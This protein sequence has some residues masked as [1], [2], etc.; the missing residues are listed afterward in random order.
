MNIEFLAED[1]RPYT[2]SVTVRPPGAEP[3]TFQAR[4]LP[5][6]RRAIEATK[7]EAHPDAALVRL[8]L[9]GWS[10]VTSTRD[11][12][13]RDVP[14]DGELLDTLLDLPWFAFGVASAYIESSLGRERGNS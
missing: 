13:A 12:A 14:F 6:G 9:I 3:M 2:H 8:V 5:L 10:G 7:S 1:P 4:F 11:G